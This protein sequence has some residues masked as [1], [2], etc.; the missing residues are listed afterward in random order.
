MER[1]LEDSWRG[2]TDI[3]V[4]G[5]GKISKKNLPIL[6]RLINIKGVIDKKGEDGAIYLNDALKLRNEEKIVVCANK[7][8]YASIRCDLNSAGLEEFIDYIKLDDFLT[9]WMFQFNKKNCIRE[10]HC[11]IST[12]CDF[13]CRK[14]N[15][16]M[17]HYDKVYVY[18]EKDI[19]KDLELFFNTVDYVFTLSFLGGEPFLNPNIEG[20]VKNAHARYHDKIGRIEIYTNG[21]ILPDDKTLGILKACDVF[22]RISDYTEQVEYSRKLKEFEALLSGHHIP[23]EINKDMRWL[24][25]KFPDEPLDQPYMDVREHMMRCNPAFHGLNDGKF[26]FCHVCWSAEKAGLFRLKETDYIDLSRIKTI[27]EKRQVVLF[28]NGEI[29]NG[30]GYISMCEVCA[31]CGDDNNNTVIAAEQCGAL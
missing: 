14:C 1:I 3:F 17:T 2:I 21:S 23:Y 8:A 25:F 12:K 16:F 11:S 15:M 24:D 5:N 9:Y 30:G 20:V 31:G 13:R 28:A 7:K 18:D 6:K 27:E 19:R 22:V 4:Y 10:V 26:Y 29:L